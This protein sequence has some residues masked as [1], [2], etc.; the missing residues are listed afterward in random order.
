VIGS[1]ATLEDFLVEWWDT[2]AVTHLRPNTLATYTTL[3]DKWIIPYL[4]RKR[5]R[6]ITRETID[7]YSARIRVDGAGPPTINRALGVLQGVFHRAVKW[8]RLSWNPVVGVR[9]VAHSRAET[10]DART[11]ETIEMIRRCLDQQ[12]A[13]L[14]SVLAYEGLRPAEAYALIWGDVIDDRG[15]PRKRLRVERAISGDEVSTTKS[16]RGRE[17]D[18]FKPVARELLEL[19]LAGGRPDPSALVFPDSRGGHLRR[20]NWRRRV[21]IPAL[22]R[23]RVPYFRSYD[24][25]PTCATLLL[26]EGRTLNEVAEHLG[27]AD[28]G[29]T[30]RTYA[31]VMRDASRRRRITI[32]EAIRKAHVAASRRLLVDPSAAKATDQQ[33]P[34]R[35][36]ALQTERADAG[37]EPGTPSLRALI[38]CRRERVW[39]REAAPLR[40]IRVATVA[41]ED[42]ERQ[43]S[44]PA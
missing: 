41:P 39:S 28:P 17:P 19:Y 21:W 34:P 36:K 44:R 11:P 10:I 22:K 33:K 13:V 30:A 23:A 4:G 12:N 31:H 27:H 24:L 9:R 26:Y 18:L 5:L 20:Q 16:E 35:K 1:N 25:R 8:R 6:E 2:Y 7:N 3:L 42:L 43:G 38:A 32:S 40:G 15:K 29:F 37:L 14:V